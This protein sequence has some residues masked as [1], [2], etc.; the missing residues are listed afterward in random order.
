M[1]LIAAGGSINYRTIPCFAGLLS[2]QPYVP[3]WGE[4]GRFCPLSNFQT[5]CRRKTENGIQ[6]LSTSSTF[7]AQILCLNRSQ[8]RSSSGQR[9]ELLLVS[10]LAT[11]PAANGKLVHA[12]PPAV[13]IWTTS[14]VF[15]DYLKNGGA[16]TK[17]T[18]GQVTRSC[19]VTSPNSLNARHGY[20]DWTMALKLSAVD[21]SSIIYKMHISKFL[22]R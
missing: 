8:F 2:T 17:V 1:L 11:E 5:I 21:T 12:R 3:H 9:S 6:I 13:S 10:M 19:Q 18:R 14:C 22:H 4:G 15:R 7:W 16:Q 20:T